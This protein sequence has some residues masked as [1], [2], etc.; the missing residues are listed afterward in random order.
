MAAKASSGEL[1]QWIDTVRQCKY[2]PENDLKKLCEIVSPIYNV[3][4]TATNQNSYFEFVFETPSVAI[5]ASPHRLRNTYSK[6]PM[7]SQSPL[8]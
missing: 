6:S 1:D 3:N 4:A 7:Y 5:N 2:L 8:L